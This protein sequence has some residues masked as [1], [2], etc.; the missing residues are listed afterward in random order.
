MIIVAGTIQFE[1]SDIEQVESHI[2]EAVFHTVQEHGCICYRF[3]RDMNT[4][5]LFQIYEEWESEPDLL[6]HLGTKH[7]TAFLT[8]LSNFNVVAQD[9]KVFE[10]NQLRSL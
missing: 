4:E 9:V 8:A 1:P 2:R 3:C 6:N 10:A 7:I 5:G